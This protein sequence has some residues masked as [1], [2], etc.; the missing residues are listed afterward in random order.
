MG[1]NRAWMIPGIARLVRWAERPFDGGGRSASTD[2]R[3]AGMRV[4]RPLRRWLDGLR[5]QNGNGATPPELPGSGPRE[6]VGARLRQRQIGDVVEVAFSDDFF[7]AGC[8]QTRV[9]GKV[10]RW[11]QSGPE[12]RRRVATLFTKEPTTIA[13]LEAMRPGELLVDIGANVGTYSVYAA[14]LSGVRVRAFEPE[15]LNFAE[16]NKNVHVNG[17]RDRVTAYCLALTDEARAG[18]LY[19][20]AFGYGYAHHDFNENTWRK[21]RYFGEKAMRRHCRL[22]QGCVSA[23]LDDLVAAGTIPCPDHVKID[24]DG[25]EHRVL[26]GA[27][28]TL[29]DPRLQTVLIE[30]NFREPRNRAIIGE[31]QDLGWRFSWDQVCAHRKGVLT[32]ARVDRMRRR[33]TGGL[34]YIFFRDE[35][36]AR[37]FADYLSGYRPPKAHR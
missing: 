24:V 4:A 37:L 6:A 8:L 2:P 17:L 5:P 29:A 15:A 26:A 7:D 11:V 32:R 21:D 16:L 25:L 28:C 20:G 1:S 30:V 27:R 23:R 14:V 10:L 12:T 22:R 36:Y 13:W 9:D 31:M 34:N 35:R 3:T 18:E 19:L 33:G